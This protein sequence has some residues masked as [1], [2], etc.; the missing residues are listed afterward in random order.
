M[1]IHLKDTAEPLSIRVGDNVAGLRIESVEFEYADIKQWMLDP[2]RACAWLENDI[3][4]RF[5]LPNNLIDL[6]H[7]DCSCLLAG[8]I[9]CPVHA[10]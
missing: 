3:F 7:P 1:K 4:V 2:V 9:Y 6:L 5:V 10:T 8:P